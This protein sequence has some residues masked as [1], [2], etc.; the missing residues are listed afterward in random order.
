[1][2]DQFEEP[3]RIRLIRSIEALQSA[4]HDVRLLQAIP[5]FPEWSPFSCTVF[6]LLTSKDGCGIS[7]PQSVMDDRQAAALRMFMEAARETGIPLIDVRGDLC[8]DGSCSTNVG[9]T[10]RYRDSFHISVDESL[11]LTPQVRSGLLR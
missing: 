9:D 1:M 7:V 4:G 8:T 6:D 2:T 11:R 5:Q 3:L 10:W